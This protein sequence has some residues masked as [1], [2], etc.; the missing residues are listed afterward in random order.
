MNFRNFRSSSGK[1][2]LLGKDSETNDELVKNF[3][4]KNNVIL[5]TSKP[6][7]PFCVINDLKPSKKDIKEAGIIV[8]SKSQDY[9]YNKKDVKVH[10]FTGKDVY[11]NK[12]MKSGTWEI[13]RKPKQILIKKREIE[14]WLL[15]N[16][17]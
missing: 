6:G 4:G 15:E 17:N 1:E 2:F 13:K 7:S 14:K 3:E 11:K 9:R 10:I 12:L 8:A 5:H 16:S